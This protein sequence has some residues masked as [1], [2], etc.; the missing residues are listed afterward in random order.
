MIRDFKHELTRVLEMFKG[1]ET[2]SNSES[3]NKILVDYENERC[4]VSLHELGSDHADIWKDIIL[5]LEKNV[6][7]TTES[8]LSEHFMLEMLGSLNKIKGFDIRYNSLADSVSFVDFKNK[9]YVITFKEIKNPNTDI[10]VD[11]ELFLQN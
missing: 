2:G 4:I 1:F 9:R 10:M 8:Q 5:Y 3:K 7:P 11:I 6:D